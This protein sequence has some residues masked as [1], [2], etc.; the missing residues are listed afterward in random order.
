MSDLD[1]GSIELETNN[2]PDLQVVQQRSTTRQD[3]SKVSD[4]TLDCTSC[5]TS[6]TMSEELGP[7]YVC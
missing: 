1:N 2:I 4:L 7:M 5:V 6:H 3:M